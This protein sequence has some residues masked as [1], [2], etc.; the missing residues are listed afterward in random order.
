MWCIMP[1]MRNLTR[2]RSCIGSIWMSLALARM[3]LMMTVLTIPTMDSSSMVKCFF[4]LFSSRIIFWMAKSIE[5]FL[6]IPTSISFL[7][8]PLAELMVGVCKGSENATRTLS[9]DNFMGINLFCMYSLSGTI[10]KRSWSRSMNS[11]SRNG[12]PICMERSST[13]VVSSMIC[14]SMRIFPN[15]GWFFSSYWE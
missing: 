10:L 3:P 5:S 8:I 11:G 7:K 13:M 4:S 15:L 2:N 12:N 1:S 14:L 9:P 6:E